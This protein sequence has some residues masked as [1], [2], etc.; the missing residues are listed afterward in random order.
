MSFAEKKV[1]LFQIVASADEEL[2]GKLIEFAKQ[3][4]EVKSSYSQEELAKF[5]TTRQKY[6]SAERSTIPIEDAHVYIRSLKKK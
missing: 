5:H 4:T 2:T 6:L 3:C 1:E